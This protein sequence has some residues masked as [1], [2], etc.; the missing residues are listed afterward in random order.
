MNGGLSILFEDEHL[1]AVDK[2]EGMHTAPLREAEKGTL[3]GLIIRRCPEV[4]HVAGLKAVEPGL[5]HRLDRDTSG[6][7]VAARTREAFEALHGQFNGGDVRKQYIAL[8]MPGSHE[9]PAPG[10]RLHIESRFAPFGPGRKRVRAIFAADEAAAGKGEATRESYATDVEVGE[11]RGGIILVR[12]TIVK[13]FRHQVRVHLA[14]LGL[15]ILGD[16]LYGAPVPEGAHR[17]MYLHAAVVALRHPASG[18]PLEIRSP[19]P[20]SFEAILS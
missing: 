18:E 4:A 12:A 14:A 19:L 9:E 10:A 3:L 13:G 17:R 8:C 16:A 7:V 6:I 11:R 2:P 15:P 20:A 5:L 1:I